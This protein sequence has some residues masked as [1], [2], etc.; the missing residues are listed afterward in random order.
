MTRNGS[1]L[2]LEG[3]AESRVYEAMSQEDI[4]KIDVR[5]VKPEK[6]DLD[7]AEGLKL[8]GKKSHEDGSPWAVSAGKMAKLIKDPMKLVRRSKAVRQAYGDTYSKDREADVWTPFREAL[9]SMGFSDEQISEI[10][11]VKVDKSVQ[12]KEVKKTIPMG[13]KPA[14][15]TPFDEN[16]SEVDEM[17]NRMSNIIDGLRGGQVTQF[18]NVNE[19]RVEVN[20][21][22]FNKFDSL[23]YLSDGKYSMFSKSKKNIAKT[24][25]F[26]KV[27]YRED[28]DG[29]VY[30]FCIDIL[31]KDG[32]DV[33]NSGKLNSPNTSNSH[34]VDMKKRDGNRV[35][36]ERHNVGLGGSTIRV[37]GVK[38]DKGENIDKGDK[39]FKHIASIIENKKLLKITTKGKPS[40]GWYKEINISIGEN[41]E[42]EYCNYFK[43]TYRNELDTILDEG[44]VEKK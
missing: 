32:Y 20:E 38:N 3:L 37:Y 28:I 29:I 10:E 13:D 16:K 8:N 6:K 15:W 2:I 4:Q 30:G 33:I 12:K 14:G 31:E 35:I 24:K 40:K 39:E 5:S 41:G 1:N 7:R 44:N 22:N 34:F 17:N 23:K 27:F 42:K 18:G 43:K 36:V 9:V 21:G 19:S 26:N 11:G 25:E